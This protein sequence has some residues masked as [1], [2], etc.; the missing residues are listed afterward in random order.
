MEP[1]YPTRVVFLAR[2]TEICKIAFHKGDCLF[3]PPFGNDGT[4][5]RY[6]FEQSIGVFREAEKIVLFGY[7]LELQIRVDDAMTTNHFSFSFE[8]F[9]P[10]T[11]H[12][13]I[14]FLVDIT[15]SVAA[16]PHLGRGR[17]VSWFYSA[18]ESIVRKIECGAEFSEF[19][20]IVVGV[21]M[22]VLSRFLCGFV[23]LLTVLVGTG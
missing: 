13:R 12:A 7:L 10:H 9:A 14:S 16:S 1:G 6:V 3:S 15:H 2:N 11:V 8:R 5:T 20:C 4:R 19:I 18:N 17:I 23:Y 21:R 22:Y